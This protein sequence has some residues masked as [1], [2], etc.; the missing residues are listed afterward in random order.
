[1]RR[2]QGTL[3][4]L[5]PAA[6][7]VLAGVFLLAAQ[8]VP[9]AHLATHRDNHTHGPERDPFAHDH[10]AD[11]DHDHDDDDHS[12]ARKADHDDADHDHGDDADHDRGSDRPAHRQHGQASAAHFGLAL[13]EGPLPPFLPP[14]A[15]TTA[16]PLDAVLRGRCSAPHPQPPARGPP[17]RI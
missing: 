4:R 1:M 6:G 5:R 7:A 14:P 11:S 9:M 16:A 3:A 13:L 15:E 12:V 10:P 8:V 2:S 17:P